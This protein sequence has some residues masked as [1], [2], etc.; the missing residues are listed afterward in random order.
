MMG[1]FVCGW[2]QKWALLNQ[3]MNLTQFLLDTLRRSTLSNFI[4]LQRM[5]WHQGLTTWQ[6]ESG[7][8]QLRKK[9]SYCTDTQTR[10]IC[11]C[12]TVCFSGISCPLYLWISSLNQC[13]RVAVLTQPLLYLI[14]SFICALS[15]LPYLTRQNIS[16]SEFTLDSN[17]FLCHQMVHVAAWAY[18]IW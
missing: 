16:L 9:E 1:Q 7:I 17:V 15:R 11:S 14:L 5:S 6:Y 10:Y 12:E 2:S 8:W 4:H 13:W 3:Q 18:I